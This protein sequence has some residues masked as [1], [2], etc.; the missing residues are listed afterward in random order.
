[1]R[2]RALILLLEGTGARIAEVLAL[3]PK[4]I[5]WGARTIFIRSG[6]GGHERVVPASPEA[7]VAARKWVD[8]R[9]GLGI[10]KGAP[11][12]TSL[13]GA[14][15]RPPSARRLLTQLG[16]QAGIKKRVHS[17]GLRYRFVARL[18]R[19]GAVVL[20]VT[21][22]LGHQSVATTYEVLRDLGLNHALDDVQRALDTQDRFADESPSAEFELPDGPIQRSKAGRPPLA[23]Q[24]RDQ[25]VKCAKGVRR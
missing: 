18:V 21:H 24:K 2:D 12:C 13:R 10:D 6:H 11:V 20:S 4:D 17:M 22:V 16:R 9:A 7:L 19:N 15:L 1:M 8:A 14:A 23:R 5:D 25:R 3:E